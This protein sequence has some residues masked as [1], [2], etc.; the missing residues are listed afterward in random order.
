LFLDTF[1]SVNPESKFQANPARRHLHK[2]LIINM[3]FSQEMIRR[4][5][6]W[7]EIMLRATLALRGA[8]EGQNGRTRENTLSLLPCDR[9]SRYRRPWKQSARRICLLKRYFRW[10]Y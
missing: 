4:F 2:P 9:A 8:F 7:E 1:P 6:E 10:D 5:Q 3:L